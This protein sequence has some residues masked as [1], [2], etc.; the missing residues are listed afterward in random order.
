VAKGYKTGG[1]PSGTPNKRSLAVAE[2]LEALG[3]DPI[4]GMA[5][6]AMDEKVEMSIRAQMY[7]ELAQY[8]AFERKAVEV[9]ADFGQ[10][11]L[12]ALKA[13]NARAKREV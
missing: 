4:E 2:K 13:V 7:K 11:Y 8:V 12:K 1:R 10:S 6:I 5:K 9:Q 3:C